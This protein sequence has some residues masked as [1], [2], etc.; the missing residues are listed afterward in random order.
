MLVMTVSVGIAL[1]GLL[2]FIPGM[3][4]FDQLSQFRLFYILTLTL[5]VLMLA[6]LRAFHALTLSFVLLV[7]TAFPAAV[8][9]IPNSCSPTSESSSTAETQLR[10]LNFNT[11]FQHNDNYK[12]FDEIVSA[13]KPDVIAIVEINQTWMDAISPTLK[14]YPFRKFVN[15]GA[16]IALFSKYPI[17]M[18]RIEPFGKS[19]HPRMVA[20]LKVKNRSVNVIVA[21]PTTP[22]SSSGFEE[23]NSEIKLLADEISV[24]NGPKI[25]IADLNCGPWSSEFHKLLKIGLIDS[26]Q[27][28]G[29]QPSWPA[30]HG[31]V[32]KHLPIPPF[33]PIDHILV[34]KEFSVTSRQAGPPIG[35]DHLP[36]FVRL[37]L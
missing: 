20:E 1:L 5:C 24:L 27:G 12:S 26:E 13:N 31:R 22:K 7:F 35:S 33:V 18:T 23:R 21:H 32:A 37:R 28:F 6:S 4:F 19:H 9:F 36:V 15:K 30:R 29:P 17:V 16:G 34:S 14:P 11:E 25:L 10:V 2:S 3:W 8:M